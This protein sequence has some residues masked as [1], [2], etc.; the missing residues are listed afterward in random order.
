MDID[1]LIEVAR[2]RALAR[3]GKGRALRVGMDLSLRDLA[4][5]VGVTPSTLALW[6]LG[7]V[8]PRPAAARRWEAALSRIAE[9]LQ[10]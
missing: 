6:E 7:R 2:I 1:E 10:E 9:S 8:R 3:S 5:A 4:G